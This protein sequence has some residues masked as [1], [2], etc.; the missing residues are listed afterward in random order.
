MNINAIISHWHISSAEPITQTYTSAWAI[1]D[2]YVLKS[3]TDLSLAKRNLFMMRTL[4]ES[5]IPVAEIIPT[6]NGDELLII[7]D[8]YFFLS[9]RLGGEH[10]WGIDEE[11]YLHIAQKSGEIIAKLHHAFLKI[12][13]TV[14]C[15]ENDL[16]TEINGWVQRVFEETSYMFVDKADF[17]KSVKNLA[18]FH[19][20]LPKQLIHRD[21]H[22]GNLLFSEGEV[23]GYI[24]FD[25][26][27][28]NIR[29]FDLCYFALGLLIDRMGNHEKM[30]QWFAVLQ[31]IVS[32]YESM[33]LL[34]EDEK[35]SAPYVMECIELLFMACF[36]QQNNG[37]FAKGA[38]E[39]Y[40]W[41]RENSA[42]IQSIFQDTRRI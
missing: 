19:M 16:L 40:R 33:T 2:H 31:S 36:Q 24:D 17:Q 1:G 14:E 22:F 9:K 27:Q 42:R 37:G 11:H 38:S 7:D 21:M 4:H 30:D 23:T 13:K 20:T 39:M 3:G 10:I 28:K 8:R 32:G 35:K 12:Q 25:L 41:I 15:W 5:G 6:V 29:I 18:K 26:S 34:T